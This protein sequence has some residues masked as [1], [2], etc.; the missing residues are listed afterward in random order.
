M[1]RL[2][3]CTPSKET[4]AH[5]ARSWDAWHLALGHMNPAA[6]RRLK[7]SGMVDGM[8]VDKTSESHQC[9]PCIQGK[10]HVKSFPKASKRMYKEIGDIV[11]TD[12][13][14]PARTRGVRGDY[15]FIS[16]TD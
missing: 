12:L 4:R 10:D 13:W 9:T 8:D 3:I 1:Y 15:Y 11:Y 7:S 5:P 2:R 16:F 6:V 14:G